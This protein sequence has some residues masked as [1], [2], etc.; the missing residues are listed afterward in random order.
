MKL[1]NSGQIKAKAYELG[2]ELAGVAPVGPSPEAAFYP[3]WLDRG[4]AGEMGY[5]ERRVEERLDPG[6]LLPDSR[7]IVVCALNYHTARP[8][9][10]TD[11]ERAWISRYAWGDD[12]HGVLEERLR[13]LAV[14]IEDNAG[15][16]TRVYVDTGPL[17]ERVHARYAGVGWFGKNTCIINQKIGSWIFLG[18][19]L[20]DLGLEYDMP[21]PDRC[22]SC[23]RCIDACPTDAIVEPYVLDSRRCISYLTIELRGA[24]PE[25][26]RDG[27]GQ[28]LF[29]CDICQDVCPWNGRA[30]SGQSD[31]FQ[32]R[33]ELF[34]PSL[35]YLLD[36]NEDGWRDLIRGTAIKRAKVR[37]LL[38]NLMVVAGNSGLKRL[39][40]KIAAYLSHEDSTIRSHAEWA[41]GK[42]DEAD[43]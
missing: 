1:V 43:R 30:P 22:G 15:V 10:D 11:P 23:T 31:A 20:T 13:R 4:F 5:L 6:Q 38:R 29:G 14:W 40:G 33:P 25:P 41:I 26:L 21:A 17:L 3:Q 2:F 36:L 16:R 19:I 9:T 28:H 18:C 12:Y 32:A 8:L 35:D 34:W 42:L 24:I 39:R 37:G 7:S 27:M